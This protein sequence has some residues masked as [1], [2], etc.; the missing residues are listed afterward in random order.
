MWQAWIN[1]A[2]SLWLVLSGLIAGLQAGI[3][4][5]ICGIILAVFGFWTPKQWPAIVV[6]VIGVWTFISGLV[7]SL[8]GQVNFLIIGIV[9]VVISLYYGL[10]KEEK[11]ASVS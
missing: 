11:T 5:I 7:P 6:G 3:N 2:V 9:G 1:F 8:V 10:K 4:M